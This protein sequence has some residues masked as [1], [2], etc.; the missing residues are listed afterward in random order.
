MKN[1]IEIVPD[2][3]NILEGGVNSPHSTVSIKSDFKFILNAVFLLNFETWVTLGIHFS[4]MGIIKIS[5]VMV[6]SSHQA[7]HLPRTDDDA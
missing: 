4:N 6:N 3:Y 2:L 7:E 5:S 1:Q